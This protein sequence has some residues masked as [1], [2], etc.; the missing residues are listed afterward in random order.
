MWGFLENAE[1]EKK[2]AIYVL[3]V[4]Q[5]FV[6]PFYWQIYLVFM[7]ATMWEKGSWQEVVSKN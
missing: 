3:I 6:V 2:R 4:S 7:T 5:D 1:Y